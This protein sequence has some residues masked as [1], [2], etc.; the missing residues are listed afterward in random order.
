MTGIIHDDCGSL[1]RYVPRLQVWACAGACLAVLFLTLSART[2]HGQE[3]PASAP[4]VIPIPVSMVRQHGAFNLSDATPIVFPA[5]D[6]DTQRIAGYLGDLIARTHGLKLAVRTGKAGNA[7]V[8]LR[9]SSDANLGAEAYLLDVQPTRITITART[10]AGLLYGAITLWQLLEPGANGAPAGA[11]QVHSAATV[12][13]MIIS[14]APRFA[15]RGVMLDSARHYQSPEFIKRFIDWMALHKLNTLHWHL[16]DDQAWRL[17]IRKYPLLTSIGAWRVPAGPTALA[18]IDPVTGRPRQY[19]GLYTQS[20]VRELVAYAAERGVTI[21]PEIEMPG[22]ASAALAAYPALAATPQAPDSVPSDW[23]IY[24]NVYNLDESTFGFLENVLT[25]VM[26]LF[27]GK[28]I[29]VGGDEV[30]KTQWQESAQV[31]ARMRELGISDPAAVQ[32][33]FTQRIGRFLQAHGRRLVGWDEILQP[34][35]PPASVVM[36]WRGTEGALAAATQG[37]DTVL[38]PWPTLYFDN[39]QSAEADEPPGRGHVISLEDVYR[40]EPQPAAL[41]KAQKNHVL[42]LQGNVWTEHIRTEDRVASMTFPRAAAVAELGWSYPERRNWEDFVRR[43]AVEFTRYDAL[44]IPHA[45][46]AFAVHARTDYL[47]ASAPVRARVELSTQSG[48]GDIRYTLDGSEPTE[49]SP[50]YQAPL[51]I[52]LPDEAQREPDRQLRAA[53]FAGVARLSQTRIIPLSHKLTLR[54]TSHELKLCSD[55][56]ALSLEDDAP[57]RSTRA[58]FLVDIE[59]PCWIFAAAD[60]DGVGGV[61]AAVGQVPF[62]FQIGDEIKK[63]KFSA[64]LTPEGELEVRLDN[65]NGELIARLPLAPAAASNAVTVLPRADIAARSGRHDLCMRFA[66]RFDQPARDPLWVLDWIELTERAPAT[67]AREPRS[68]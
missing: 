66:Q 25:E 4:A 48:A 62:N 52:A 56:I 19:G 8:N 39:R 9:R 7:A 45:G 1:A 11:T 27:P 35:L 10:N 46:S 55:N 22:H 31:Q 23:G 29:H 15:W 41:S 50:R 33:Y 20:T 5:R 43:L 49:R 21:V 30:E 64:P 44:K 17:E 59:N 32:I 3:Q 18:D 6:R 13:A 12:P 47:N 40:F 24:A 68:P 14:D 60:L 36:S 34:G 53:A 58:V 57:L 37:F 61:V 16:T 63:I 26:A 54:R 51:I 2:A 67:A 38:S 65:C 28:Y 42:G